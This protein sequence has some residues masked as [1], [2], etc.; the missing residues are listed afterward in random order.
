MSS[1]NENHS[2]DSDILTVKEVAQYLRK[3][4]SWVYRH[5]QELGASKLGGSLLFRKVRIDGR[6]SGEEQKDVQV[7]LQVPKTAAHKSRVQ[8]ETRSPTSRSREKGGTGKSAID[9]HGN[10]GSVAS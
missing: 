3:S 7:Q 5:Q 4:T 2:P 6:L 8:D 1:L 9:R 10:S